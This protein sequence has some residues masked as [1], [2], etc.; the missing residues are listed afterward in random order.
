MSTM[1]ASSLASLARHF[2]SIALRS[3]APISARSPRLRASSTPHS[4][5]ASR[6][7][8]TRNLSSASSIL[9][10]PPHRARSDWVA[11][12]VLELAAREDQRTGEGIDLVMAHDHEHFERRAGIS[13]LGR[14][15]QQHGGGGTRRRRLFLRFVHVFL[16]SCDSEVSHTSGDSANGRVYPDSVHSA[17]KEHVMTPV[18]QRR[19]APESRGGTEGP[20]RQVG[21]DRGAGRRVPDRRL[22]RAGQRGR[23]HRLGGDDHRHHDDHG[24]RRG[25]RGGLQRQGLGQVRG[26]DA[27]RPALCRRRH[28]R[29]R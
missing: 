27:A 13:R 20:A 24:R 6:T 21:M 19:P 1:L 29:P 8:A 16:H 9:S 4:S 3:A 14:A 15:Q 23:R 11:V 18:H 17:L 10:A 12:G 7:P 28:H 2:V 26:L 22:H 25:N 5:N